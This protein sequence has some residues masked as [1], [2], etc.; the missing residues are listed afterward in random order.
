[1]REDGMF[2]LGII[3]RLKGIF[4]LFC[5]VFLAE[6]FAGIRGYTSFERALLITL[7]IILLVI[8]FLWL[9]WARILFYV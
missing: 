3:Y 1:M 8:I 4:I 7:L 5:S 6:W 9:R 2:I